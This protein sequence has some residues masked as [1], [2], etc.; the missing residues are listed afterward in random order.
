[1]G[2]LQQAKGEYPDQVHSDHMVLLTVNVVTGKDDTAVFLSLAIQKSSQNG[3]AL[4]L[5]TLKISIHLFSLIFF[6]KTL[7]ASKQYLIKINGL[8]KWQ[9]A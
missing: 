8:Q 6:S 3:K 2:I 7:Y 9:S 4:C 1:M 5:V